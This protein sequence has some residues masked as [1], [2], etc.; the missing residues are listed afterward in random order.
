MAYQSFLFAKAC[1]TTTVGFS[2]ASKSPDMLFS[3]S[4]LRVLTPLGFL[5]TSIFQKEIADQVGIS[6]P[7]L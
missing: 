3:Y 1:A 6:Q 4:Q 5:V 7:S 2:G